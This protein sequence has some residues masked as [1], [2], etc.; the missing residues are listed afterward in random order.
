MS[1][2]GLIVQQEF[3]PEHF[4]RIVSL[5]LASNQYTFAFGPGGLGVLRDVTGGYTAALLVCI[6]LQGLAAVVVLFRKQQAP[7]DVSSIG[8]A[9]RLPYQNR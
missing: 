5:I 8:A 4:G 1:L 9:T 6:L 7:V 3:P 2:P